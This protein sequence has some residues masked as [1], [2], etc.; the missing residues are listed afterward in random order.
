MHISKNKINNLPPDPGCYLFKNSDSQVLYVGKAKNLKKRV[1]SYFRKNTDLSP[2][3]QQMMTKIADIDYFTVRTE[4]EALILEAN[5]IKKHQP[6]YNI[7]LKDD[8]FFLYLKITKERFPRITTTRKIEND[9][10]EYFGPFSSS[11]TV[12]QTLKTLK[13]IYPFRTDKQNDFLFDILDYKNKITPDEYEQSIK[14]IKKIL[15]G[16]SSTVEKILKT[17]MQAASQKRLYEK[18]ARLRDQL[19]NL[20]KLTSLQQAILPQPIDIDII[21]WVEFKNSIYL[22]LIK[23][24]QGKLIDKINAKLKNCQETPAEITSAFIK[25]YYLFLNDQPRI[26]ITPTDV[27]IPEK[28]LATIF[29]KKIKIKK[30]QRGKLKKLLELAHLNAQNFA[31]K[32]QAS[33]QT[34]NNLKA[35]LANL[36]KKLKLKNKLH[37]IECYDVSNIQGKHAVGSMVVFTNGQP[38]KRQYRKFSIK[39]TKGQAN[40]FAMLAEIV[41]RRL[42]HPEWPK[43]DLI[44]LDGGKGQLSVVR[45]TLQNLKNSRPAMIALAK[46][47]EEIFLPNN[48]KSLLLKPGSSEYFLIQRIRDEA[49]R[50]AITFYRSKHSRS[51]FK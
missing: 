29:I 31:K 42:K 40:D 37:R 32:S 45:K 18:A 43:P 7:I 21:N 41:A 35:G 16:K 27:E 24:R 30:P 5:L 13:K 28:D 1:A 20:K 23:I 36:Q 12:K 11:S 38:D 51:Y 19:K 33:F 50:F 49:H 10:C 48:K 3:K 44:I 26:I 6:A 34:A 46:K 22:T 8:K 2:A 17:Q 9:N 4:E 47:Q 14:Q 25:Q 15:G 39:Y